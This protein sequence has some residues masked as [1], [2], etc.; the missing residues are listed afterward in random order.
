MTLIDYLN[1]ALIGFAAIIC[2]LKG[3][4]IRIFKKLASVAS[5][6]LACFVGNKYNGFLLSDIDVIGIENKISRGA[7]F[8]KNMSALDILLSILVEKRLL[9]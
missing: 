3:F 1:L 7:N 8:V 4:K 9:W 6:V 2:V 5:V